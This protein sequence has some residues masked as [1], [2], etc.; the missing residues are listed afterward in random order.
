MSNFGRGGTD[1]LL[2]PDEPPRPGLTTSFEDWCERQ[3]VHPE[4]PEAW[5]RFE[6]AST[7][8]PPPSPGPGRGRA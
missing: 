3:G 4:D 2:Y 7:T 1:C 5:E 6:R 8:P